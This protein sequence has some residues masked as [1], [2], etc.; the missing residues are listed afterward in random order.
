MLVM[1]GCLSFVIMMLNDINQIFNQYKIGKYAFAIGC[2]LL[3]MVT[4]MMIIKADFSIENTGALQWCLLMM[5]IGSF[6]LLIYTLFF[7][8]P[9]KGTYIE[10]DQLKV[11]DKGVYALCRHPGVLWLF[12]F[13]WFLSLFLSSSE[14]RT[15][16]VMFSLMNFIYAYLQDKLIFP[17][18]LAGYDEYQKSV[19]FLIPTLTSCKQCL[20]K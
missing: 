1:I 8:L 2:I 13:Y 10:Q 3:G 20:R 17:R 16:A 18:T 12:F 19:P 4:I 15:A 14:L 6:V 7:A 11:Y 5:S 9:F